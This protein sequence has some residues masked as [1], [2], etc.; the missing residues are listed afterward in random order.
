MHVESWI[1][2]QKQNS[3]ISYTHW[4]CEFLLCVRNF[5]GSVTPL[6]YFISQECYE[7]ALLWFRFT[8]E[9]T[10]ACEL[11]V[12]CARLSRWWDRLQLMSD[13]RWILCTQ[14]YCSEWVPCLGSCWRTPPMA[15]TWLCSSLWPPVHTALGYSHIASVSIRRVGE[16]FHQHTF[17]LSSVWCG[18]CRYLPIHHWLFLTF[19]LICIG[20]ALW[21]LDPQSRSPGSAH[22]RQAVTAALAT[23]GPSCPCIV[24]EKWIHQTY[25][26]IHWGA[27]SGLFCLKRLVSLSFSFLSF[28]SLLFSRTNICIIGN[29]FRY[30]GICGVSW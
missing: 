27:F 18:W 7:M 12:M 20:L 28:L 9:E 3:T 23:R 11:L 25:C 2:T 1:G 6:F 26:W 19:L 4:D 10:K 30:C 16:R 24:T 8:D 14:R 15:A 29:V 21:P 22:V 5:I 17:G 13:P